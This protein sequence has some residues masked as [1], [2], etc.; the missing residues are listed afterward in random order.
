MITDNLS[1]VESFAKVEIMV[2]GTF[3]LFNVS[4]DKMGYHL[5]IQNTTSSESGDGED[6]G[7]TFVLVGDQSRD[8]YVNFTVN[9]SAAMF[10]SMVLKEFIKE[11]KRVGKK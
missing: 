9:Y 4:D 8:N 1:K 10:L 7:I 5:E 6:V 11:E 2:D 3:G